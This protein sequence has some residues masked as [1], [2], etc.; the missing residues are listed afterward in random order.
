M[1]N[2]KNY[3]DSISGNPYGHS[4]FPGVVIHWSE[5]RGAY[6][7]TN[8]FWLSVDI[9]FR[10]SSYISYDK[11]R[12]NYKEQKKYI[13]NILRK[14]INRLFSL[15]GRTIAVYKNENV[16]KENICKECEPY[17]FCKKESEK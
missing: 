8:G 9:E 17:N 16:G 15:M 7:A 3:L 13:D 4:E 11:L 14:K 10:D 2:L 5:E 12:N 6:K 1:K